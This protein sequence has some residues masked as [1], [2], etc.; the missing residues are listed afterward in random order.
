VGGTKSKWNLP[1]RV[2]KKEELASFSVDSESI[3]D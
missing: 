2:Y 1:Y 3:R